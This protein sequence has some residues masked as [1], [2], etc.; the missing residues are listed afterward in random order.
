MT[1]PYEFVDSKLHERRER[2]FLV[3]AGVFIGAMAMLNIIG[4][5]RFIEIP[6]PLPGFLASWYGAS[7]FPLILA[8]GVLP[9]PLTFLCTDLIS[10]F[11]GQR[12]ANFVVF[13]GLLVNVLVM[14]VMWLGHAL[15]GAGLTAPPWQGLPLKGPVSLP[16]ETILSGD[17]VELFDF[18]YHL[19]A[20]S[21]VASMVAYLTAQ[22]CDVYVFHFWKN[23]TRGK[24]LWLRNN[25]S[26]LVS[27][28]V[29]TIAVI[30]ITFGGQ[31]LR[32]A[33]STHD[34]LVLIGGS[35]A[36]KAV[37]ALLDTIPIYILVA[38]LSRY[39]QIDPIA[40]H[41]GWDGKADKPAP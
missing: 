40:E 3:L 19:T 26:T 32:G 2:V 4:I 30:G 16:G 12:R 1:L 24:H 25:G 39:L 10:E 35:Y 23:L 13:V 34:I 8:V 17:H 27:Q 33:L 7:A 21:V 22:L 11:Y 31:Y 41:R 5:T 14:G 28:M 36:F 20:A 38:W 15:P 37:A 9:Y 18:L 29:D 6:I